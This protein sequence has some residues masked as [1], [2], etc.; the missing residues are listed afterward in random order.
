MRVVL[1]DHLGLYYIILLFHFWPPNLIIELP[2]QT[3][4]LFIV[5]IF[6]SQLKRQIDKKQSVGF[7][8][9]P[10]RTKVQH[11]FALQQLRHIFNFSSGFGYF[12]TFSTT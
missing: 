11:E 12:L 9:Q 5:Y 10:G 7:S 6:H 8:V 3:C 2:Q 4:E 1:G